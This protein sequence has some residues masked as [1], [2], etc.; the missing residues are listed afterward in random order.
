VILGFSE[1]LAAE[2]LGPFNKIPHYPPST[3]Q[4]GV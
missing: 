4:A 2:A 3:A 1:V